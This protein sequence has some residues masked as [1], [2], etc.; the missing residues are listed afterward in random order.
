MRLTGDERRALILNAA[1]REFSRAGYHGAST[2]RIA[3]SAD[4]SE[5]MLYKHFAGKQE[6]FTAVLEHT[7]IPIEERFDQLLSLPGNMLDNW[8]AGIP[9]LYADPQ[10]AETMRLRMLALSAIDDPKVRETLA[11]INERLAERIRGA[12]ER[13]QAE[14]T[15]HADVDPAYVLWIWI[16]IQYSSCYREAMAPGTYVEMLPHVQHFI[17]SLRA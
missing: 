12:I 9:L 3:A 7:S 10:Y 2:S 1:H 8:N 16:G 15:M 14:G 4:C 6:L 13:A 11:G 5:P 17:G